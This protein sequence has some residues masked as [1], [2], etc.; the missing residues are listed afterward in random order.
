MDNFIQIIQQ[1]FSI[2]TAPPGNLIYHLGLAFSVAGALQAAFGQWRSNP[3][4]AMR[5]MVFGLTVLL[6]A[7]VILFITVME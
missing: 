6:V 2:L 3:T 7:Q 5:R 4:S 1:I